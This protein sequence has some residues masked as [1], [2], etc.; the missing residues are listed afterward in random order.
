[1]YRITR[2]FA[3]KRTTVSVRL[4]AI[5]SEDVE[6]SLDYYYTIE[7]S[8]DSEHW[9]P[10]HDMKWYNYREAYEVLTHLICKESESPVT[11]YQ[12]NKN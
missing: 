11:E 8:Y 12:Y 4:S 3:W 2:K 5:S 9:I 10:C 1:M 6:I 7:R